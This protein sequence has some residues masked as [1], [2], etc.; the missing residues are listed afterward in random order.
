MLPY[1]NNIPTS[2]GY[3][4][5]A[6]FAAYEMTSYTTSTSVAVVLTAQLQ[7]GPECPLSIKEKQT[8]HFTTVENCGAVWSNQT[9]VKQTAQGEFNVIHEVYLGDGIIT[10]PPTRQLNLEQHQQVI[11]A[12]AQNPTIASCFKTAVSQSGGGGGPC[13]CY[14]TR[15]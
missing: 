15:A 5:P 8:V 2:L 1:D 13:L 14:Y 4:M 7:F 9:Y 12:I 10:E 11:Q 6:D 3:G